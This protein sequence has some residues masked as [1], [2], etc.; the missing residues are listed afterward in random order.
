MTAHRPTA[1]LTALALLSCL[2]VSGPARASFGLEW[3]TPLQGDV[4]ALTTLVSFHTS[5]TNSGSEADDYTVTVAR[6]A[7]ADWVV[8]L[9]EGEVCYPP[10]VTQITVAVGAGETAY[11]DVDVTPLLEQGY[12]GCNVTVTSQG[13]PLLSE[14]RDF[15]VVSTGLDLLLVVDDTTP[16]LTSYWTDALA[17]TGKTYG[18]WKPVQMGALSNLDLVGFGTVV[19]S[20]GERAGALGSDDLSALAYYVQH[21]GNLLLSGRDLAYEYLDAGS[22]YYS[23]LGEAWFN[24]ILGVDHTGPVGSSQAHAYGVAGDLITT[25]LDFD[26]FGGDGA[27]NTA[28]TLDGIAPVNAGAISLRYG[29][30]VTGQGAAIRSLYGEGRSWFCSF[31]FEA[32]ATGA[33]RAQLLQNVLAWFDG[34]LVPA[35]EV[36]RPLLAGAAHATPNPFNP[37]TTLRFAVGG[38]RDVPAEIVIHD[39]RGQ[40]VRR[41]FRGEVTPGPQSFVWNGRTDG[42][43]AAATGVYLARIELDG[44]DAASV[45][46]TLVK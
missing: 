35:G 2:A 39:L 22:P 40:V 44:A 33:D 26:L 3:D 32:I 6:S 27:D 13:D 28:L 20:A 38:L 5:I 30:A 23:P 25:G 7:P 46:M 12:G 21:G 1:I 45:K 43:Q 31:A 17:G 41:L 34:Q 16:A 8:S 36:T 37:Q 11:L 10:F 14:S 4:A 24:L 19:W 15:T 42:G 18:I 9:C 29:D